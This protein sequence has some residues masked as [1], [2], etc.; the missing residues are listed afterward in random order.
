M[1][2]ETRNGVIMPIKV[3]PRAHQDE[4]AGWENL[5]VKI[6]IRAVPEK[7]NANDALLRFIAKHLEV[8]LSSVTLISGE[9]SRHKRICISGLTLQ[10]VMAKLPK[11]K[12]E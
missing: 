1:L 3:I 10:Q 11:P 6:K 4:I 8:P 2:K 12:L 7:G 5:E 9:S